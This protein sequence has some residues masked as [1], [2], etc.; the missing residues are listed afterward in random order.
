M[1]G[2]YIM[3]PVCESTYR[4][5]SCMCLCAPQGNTRNLTQHFATS[6]FE[7]NSL[8]QTQSSLEYLGS[9][10][11]FSRQTSSGILRLKLQKS[12]L[13]IWVYVGSGIKTLVIIFMTQILHFLGYIPCTLQWGYI[14]LINLNRKLYLFYCEV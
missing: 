6:F 3:F 2:V 13:F 1:G 8:S 4:Y 12:V 7:K 5:I 9:L 10:A 14:P 11:S